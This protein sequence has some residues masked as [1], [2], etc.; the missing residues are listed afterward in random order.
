MTPVEFME[1][2]PDGIY[3]KAVTITKE[4]TDS[5]G[6]MTPG[7]LMRRMQHTA[8]EHMNNL[9]ITG[10]S[11]LE[12][13]ALWVL[14]RNALQIHR[15]PKMDEHVVIR[16]WF[17]KEKHCMNPSYY[18]CY[19]STGEELA[20][21]SSQWLAI[22]AITRRLTK[23]PELIQRLTAKTVPDK[24]DPPANLVKFPD[25]LPEH[26]ERTVLPRHIDLNGHMSNSFYLDWAMELPEKGYLQTHAPCSLWIEY[27][28]ELMLGETVTLRY[29][30][31]QNTL[32]LRG[33][34]GEEE[35]FALK[36]DF[37]TL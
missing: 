24:L 29:K 23:A 5:S 14:V 3:Q 32:F 1:Q 9:G 6:E 27:C 12:Q 34:A 33:F 22:D 7:T 25:E 28:R 17:G 26:V 21:V 35:S 8:V 37:G 2:C 15:M 20:S 16:V 31:E 18:V 10:E 36:L 30:Q 19:S 13:G 11:M 4:D